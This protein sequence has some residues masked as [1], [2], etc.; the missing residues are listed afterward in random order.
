MAKKKFSECSAWRVGIQEASYL[1]CG[2]S[3]IKSDL[4]IL[5]E[6]TAK[7]LTASETLQTWLTSSYGDYVQLTNEATL[8]ELRQYWIQYKTIDVS[9]KID[10]IV[11]IGMLKRSKEIGTS[12]YLHGLRSA[13]PLWFSGMEVSGHSYRKYWETGVAGGNSMDSKALGEKGKGYANPM[14]AVSSAPSGEFAVHYGSE[15]LLG[16]NLA[17]TFRELECG[18]KLHLAAQSDRLVEAAKTQFTNW[19]GNF[20]KLVKK[21]RVCTQL[22]HGDAIALCQQLQLGTTSSEPADRA[23]FYIKPW[24][25]QALRLDGHASLK[26]TRWPFLDPFD[27]IDTS[28][29]GDHVGLINMVVATAPLLRSQSTSVLFTETLLAVSDDPRGSLSAALGTDVATFSMLIGLAPIGILAGTTLEAVSNEAGLQGTSRAV[30]SQKQSQYRLRVHWRSPDVQPSLA[31]WASE[32]KGKISRRVEADPEGL[33]AWLFSVYRK[34]FAKEDV[35]NLFPAALRMQSNQYSTDIQRY[36]RAAIVAL[37]RVIKTKVLT[38]WDRMM[39]TF[40][41]MVE[42]D[43]SLLVGSNSL[44]ELNMHLALFGVWTLPVLAKG[45]RRVQKTFNLPLRP[46]SNVEGLLGGVDPPSI[47]HIVLSV[48][49]KCLDIFRKTS[50]TPGMHIAVK[51][52]FGAQQYENSFYSFHCCFGKFSQNEEDGG[53]PVFEEDDKGWLGSADLVIICPV[54]TFGL[55]MGPRSGLKVSLALNTSPENAALFTSKLGLGLTV[56]ETSLENQHRVSICEDPPYLSTHDFI[57]SQQ[58]WLQKYSDGAD[59]ETAAFVVLDSKHRAH[60][61][62]IRTTFTQ[63]SEEA[64]ALAGGASVS[65]AAVDSSTVMLK[66]GDILSRP[67]VFPFPV[68]SSSSKTRIARKSSWIEVE[69]A[70]HV[71]PQQD[72]FDTWTKIHTT[73]DGSFSLGSIPRVNLDVQPAI[74]LMTKKDHSWLNILM[75]GTLSESEKQLKDQGSDQSTHP[76]LEL[77]ESLNIIFQS[78]AGFHP[79]TQGPVHTFQLTL[80]RNNSCH[81]LLF[82]SGMRHD[83]DLGSVVLDAWVLPLTNARV[84]KLSS[85]IQGL[86]SAKPRPLG[87]YLSDKESILWKRLLPALAE[88]CRNWHHKA[89]CEYRI[90]GAIPLSVEENQNPLCGCGEDKVSSSFA[91]V[92]QWAPFTKYV[93]RVAIAPVFPVPY[94]ESLIRLSDSE[95]SSAMAVKKGPRCDNCNVLSGQLLVCGKCGRV[96]YCSK[97]CQRAAWKGHKVLCKT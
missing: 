21:Q 12:S 4:V 10:K 57:A 45:P 61:L 56:F 89:T 93:T 85:A 87:V 80:K 68:Q 5:Q 30:Q 15:P 16:F 32:S 73:L 63:G 88:R 97:E 44:Q 95:E 2:Q 71:A 77:K 33:A 26:E 14:F 59:T 84:E 34:M 17:E 37:I 24:K 69:A 53:L 31:C 40:L 83:L 22:F 41:D 39:G 91:K 64:K 92:K 47:V 58:G 23:K 25:L 62:Q 67:L 35:S 60:K 74:S 70:I 43:R 52:Q 72:A 86:L 20:A 50:A 29:L 81:T 54:P 3:Q 94:V 7:L 65:A 28:N 13:G 19:I 1:P 90:K 9:G 38:D 49:R 18:K 6:H 79:K 78:F 76:K 8:R 36:T 55:L 46:R 27:I 51:Q 82:I 42:M 96:R 75:G 66:L 11:R 48:P